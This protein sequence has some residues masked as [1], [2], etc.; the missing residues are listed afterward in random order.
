MSNMKVVYLCGVTE[1]RVVEGQSYTFWG[2]DLDHWWLLQSLELQVS[3][4]P[5]AVV[6]IR[7]PGYLSSLSTA[8]RF[9]SWVFG[10]DSLIG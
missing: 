10:C 8:G 2:S 4:G 6:R 1:R 9:L 5:S 3:L 7:P